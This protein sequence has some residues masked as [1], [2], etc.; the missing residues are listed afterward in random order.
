MT[1]DWQDFLTQRGATIASGVAQNFGDLSAELGATAQGTVLCDLGQFGTLRVSGEEAQTFLQNLLSNDI[2]AVTSTRAQFSS[3]NTAKGRML[4]SMLIWREGDDYLLQLPRELCEPIR[5]KL[6]M[7]VLRARVKVADASEGIVTLGLSGANARE[8]LQGQFGELPQLPLSL[9]VRP[10]LVEGLD[11]TSEQASTGS[12]RTDIFIGSVLKISNTRFQI[13]TTPQQAQELWNKLAAQARPVG[14]ACW[15]WL[16][17]RAGIPVILP[18]TQEQFV[19]QMVNFDLINGVSFSKGC[20]PGQEI[21]ARTQYLGKL[22]RRMYL[23]HI[24]GPAEPQP[25]DELFSADMEGQASGMVANVAPAPSGGYDVLTVVQIASRDAYPVHI[26][27]LLGARLAFQ[28]LPY[29]IP[30]QPS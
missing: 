30:D 17:I 15:D 4:A 6:S 16:N 13:S 5:K 9:A 27:S 14:S 8:I 20:Y 12:A 11:S 24:D 23:A 28:A 19:A 3:L 29:Q 7:Y 18:Q 22:K 21:V 1:P 26:S 2:R 10:E 25:G